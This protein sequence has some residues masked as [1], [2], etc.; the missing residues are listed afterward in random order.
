MFVLDGIDDKGHG[1]FVGA[2]KVRAAGWSDVGY[3]VPVGYAVAVG[4]GVAG[5][6]DWMVN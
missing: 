3:G 5:H 4:H 1:G 2:A 6:G